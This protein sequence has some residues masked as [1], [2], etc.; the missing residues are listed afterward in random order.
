M[1]LMMDFRAVRDPRAGMGRAYPLPALLTM[2]VLALIANTTGTRSMSRWMQLNRVGLNKMLGLSW[3]KTPTEGALRYLLK[4]IAATDLE[5]AIR[6]TGRAHGQMLQVDGK[7]LRGRLADHPGFDYLCTVFSAER[8][9][10]LAQTLHGAGHEIKAAED[11]LQSLDLS[12][13]WVSF[14]ALHTQ[15]KQ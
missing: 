2:M 1:G 14:D 10:V 6:G 11:L 15:K 9:V 5:S 4:K 3:K 13:Q 7:A 8:E 12:G